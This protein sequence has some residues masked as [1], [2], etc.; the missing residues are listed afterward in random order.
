MLQDMTRGKKE[1]ERESR[2]SQMIAT[3]T[4][5]TPTITITM[6]MTTKKTY[7][8]ERTSRLVRLDLPPLARNSICIFSRGF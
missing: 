5:T 2:S 6:T 1:K 3:T 7:F 8:L 4:T